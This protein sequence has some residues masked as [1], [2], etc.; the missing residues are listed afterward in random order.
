[1]TTKT[2]N[3]ILG[4]LTL[5]IASAIPA[6][7][8]GKWLEAIIFVVCHTLIRPQFPKQYH[9]IIPSMCRTITAC[10]FF[11]GVSFTL[12]LE[13]SLLSAIPINYF[14]SWIGFTKAQL[15]KMEV[16]YE[17]L[18]DKLDKIIDELNKYKNIDLYQM[19]ED[20][21]RAFGAS[22]KLSEIQQDILVM[23][24]IQHLKISEICNYRNYGR[25]T[26]KYHLAEIKEKL[27]ID[28]V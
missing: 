27:K 23:R 8:F 12:P 22:N 15:N 5:I 2:K 17:K 24:V 1:M 20:N 26:I 19:P 14:I 4:Y 11:F 3:T 9:H 13:I 7:I 25:S 16:M 28:Y 18:Q 21:L 6:I 10:V